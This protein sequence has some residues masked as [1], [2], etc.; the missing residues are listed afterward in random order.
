MVPLVAFCFV[1]ALVSFAA[2]YAVLLVAFQ[3]IL[4]GFTTI[5][6][7]FVAWALI[8]LG[9]KRNIDRAKQRRLDQKARIASQTNETVVRLKRQLSRNADNLKS[10][11]E[12]ISD[13]RGQIS[14]LQNQLSQSQDEAD[15][16]KRQLAVH[17]V[18]AQ[19][20]STTKRY[21]DQRSQTRS[22]TRPNV[23]IRKHLD[24]LIEKQNAICGICYKPLPY[25]PTGNSV[26]VDHIIPHSLGGSDDKDN[27]QVTHAQCN[28]S[29]GDGLR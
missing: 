19:F 6:F 5:W 16:L 25:P 3:F 12:T 26:H 28:L 17:E 15:L 18:N 9:V 13:F 11:E 21:P 24:Y 1:G 7:F 4:D 20:R 29:K 2:T 23:N 22:P 8:G 14:I 10:K 27:L